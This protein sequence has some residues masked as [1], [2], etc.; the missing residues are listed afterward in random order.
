MSDAD[1]FCS[2]G[3]VV[4]SPIQYCIDTLYKGR[5]V[6]STFNFITH[7]IVVQQFVCMSAI[8]GPHGPMVTEVSQLFDY[9]SRFTIMFQA[10]RR[11]ASTSTFSNGI[12]WQSMRRLP[13]G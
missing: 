9:G 6:S 7:N 3:G 13:S 4:F 11:C 8:L 10:A 2:W 1:Q 12:V 5:H